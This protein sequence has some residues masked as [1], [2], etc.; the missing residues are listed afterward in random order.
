[1]SDTETGHRQGQARSG[2]MIGMGQDTKLL[3]GQRGIKPRSIKIG[4]DNG[5]KGMLVPGCI[6]VQVIPD[7]IA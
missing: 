1:M 6:T 2:H 5:C 4:I 7:F 3:S